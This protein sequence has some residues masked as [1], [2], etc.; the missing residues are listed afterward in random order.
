[1]QIYFNTNVCSITN[2]IKL[3]SI[4]INFQDFLQVLRIFINKIKDT[5]STTAKY[6]KYVMCE[7]RYE[8]IQLY[9]NYN[10][11]VHLNCELS[12]TMQVC[13]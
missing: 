13:K 9:K 1:M 8:I 7:H 12:Q 4:N 11:I 10:T 3:I 2:H 6:Y 5:E